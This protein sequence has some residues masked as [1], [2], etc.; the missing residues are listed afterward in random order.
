V[1]EDNGLTF[2]IGP[3]A[4]TGN[5]RSPSADSIERTISLVVKELPAPLAQ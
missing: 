5:R 3:T 2:R 1:T 4:P